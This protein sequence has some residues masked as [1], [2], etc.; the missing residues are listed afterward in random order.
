GRNDAIGFDIENEL[1]QVGALFD[2][3][4]FD[5][6]ADA[7][8]GAVR[9]IQHDAADGVRAVVDQGAHVAGHIAA[10]LLDLDVDLELACLGKVCNNVIGIDDLDVVGQLDVGGRD[11]ALAFFAQD[12]G[13]VFAVMQLENHALEVKQDVD[14]VFAYARD[15]GVFVH[16]AR[17]LDFGRRVAG[18]GRQQDAAQRIAQSV[19]IAALEGLHDH[20]SAIFADGFD[21]DRTGFQ[22][23]LR[24]HVCSFSIPSARYTDKADG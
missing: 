22:K 20:A 2:T 23:T 19:A 11:H 21:F 8:H 3:S 10:P 1:V 7:A 13:D 9:S 16:D 14:H 6:I 24:R 12:Q 17:D 5:G 15:G 4:A 18:H